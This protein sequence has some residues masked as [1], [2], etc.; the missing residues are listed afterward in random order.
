MFGHLK[1]EEF[2]NAM[3]AE[4]LDKARLAHLNSCAVCTAQFRSLEAVRNDLVTEDRNIPEPDWNNFRD[5]VRLE[6]L[7]RSVQRETTVRR[8]TGW[9]IRPAMAWALSF[10]L[11]IGVSVGGFLWHVRQDAH[12]SVARMSQE[13]TETP[14]AESLAAWTGTDVF[15]E[16]SNLEEPQVE[17]LRLL[18]ESAQHSGALK[19]Q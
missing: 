13:S 3:E 5:S 9:A 11:L 10:A 1:P 16:L 14:D 7:S 4:G 18:V 2:M 8:W 17:R 6:L 19:R 15:Q 12:K